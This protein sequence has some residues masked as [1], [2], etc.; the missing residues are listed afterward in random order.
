MEAGD[1]AITNGYANGIS[2]GHAKTNGYHEHNGHID[3]KGEKMKEQVCI[4]CC[5]V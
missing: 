3:C 5:R 1:I 2:N 4:H